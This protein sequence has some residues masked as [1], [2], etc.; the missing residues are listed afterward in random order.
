MDIHKIAVDFVDGVETY[1]I[2]DVVQIGKQ[3][4]TITNIFQYASD[5]DVVD[6]IDEEGDTM[7]TIPKSRIIAYFAQ[8][9]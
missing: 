4:R 2:G 8:G 7:I 1:E 9:K 5:T 6:I 3:K